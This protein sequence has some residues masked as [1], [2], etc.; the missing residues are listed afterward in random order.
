MIDPY[1]EAVLIRPKDDDSKDAYVDR[2]A[3]IVSHD[4]QG[5]FEY[6]VFSNSPRGKEYR[7]SLDRIITLGNPQTMDLTEATAIEVEGQWLHD[8]THALRFSS[9][10]GAWIR[11]FFE[12]SNRQSHE[13]YPESSVR[14]L[15]DEAH[16]KAGE[17][18]TH[19]KRI[20]AALPH[21]SEGKVHPT[22]YA[23]KSLTTIHPESALAQF[24]AEAPIKKFDDGVEPIFPFY[25]NISQREAAMQ[26]LRNSISII[27]GPPGTGKTQTILNIIA[28]LIREPGASVGV[29]SFNNAAVN[30]VLSKLEGEG[31]G[32]VVANLGNNSRKEEFFN[33][34][35]ERNAAVEIACATL[36]DDEFNSEELERVNA[37]LDQLQHDER[38]LAQTRDEA[39]AFL[40]E[41]EHFQR[42]LD[43]HDVQDLDGVPILTKASDRILDFIVEARHH[44]DRN[45]A[46]RWIRRL[47]WRV[48]YGSLRD[49]DYDDSGT[50]LRLQ[51]AYYSRKISELQSQ[52]DQLEER[53]EHADLKGLLAKQ[54]ELSVHAFEHGLHRR[55]STINRTN[56]D[57]KT[58]RKNFKAFL[59]DYPV[60]LSTCHSLRNSMGQGALL[61]YIIID[62]ASQLDLLTG[63]LA[64][65]SCKRL[66]VVGDLEQLPHIADEKAAAVAGP[67]PSPAH[68]YTRHSVLSSLLE[69]YGDNIPRT[70]LREHYRCHP[71]IIGFCNEEFYGEQLI[72]CRESTPS[73]T[74]LRLVRTPPGNHM[75]QH[76]SGGR[77][78]RREAEVVVDEII[79]EL[80]KTIPRDDIGV[81]S[82]YRKQVETMA[83]LLTVDHSDSVE[84]DTV[85]RY[86]GREKKVIVMSTVL[87]ETWRGRTGT[88]FVDDPKL[89]NVAVSRAIEQF[90]LVTDHDMLPTSHHL[91]D[92]MRYIAYHNPGEGL[93][94]SQIISVFDLLYKNYSHRLRSLASRLGDEMKYLSEE[95]I[96]T[97]L[98]D[99]LAEEKYRGLNVQPQILLRNL[100]PSLDGLTE[101]QRSFVRHNASLDF[102]IY[103]SMSRIPVLAIEVN[104]FAFHEN[105]PEQL[106]RDKIKEATLEN[107]GLHL[108]PLATTESRE[109]ERIRAA[110]DRAMQ[111]I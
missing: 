95:I 107:H 30:N 73:P 79:K 43:G 89:V 69:V 60:L 12:N 85:H 15:K 108:L 90:I 13:L 94:E 101:R 78:N 88:V 2:T 50:I 9:P 93:I 32:Y 105:N 66:I 64:L 27:D 3:E 16:R 54:K 28:S 36:R 102:V 91:R 110:L 86:Q 4:R 24:L 8:A 14:F 82:P 63:A 97:L 61:D 103:H 44:D 87:D 71:E 48:L 6:V 72:P 104:G 49:V 59:D 75:R 17:I 18:L 83:D 11:F 45:W 46:S 80:C 38:L 111:V 62:E 25:S 22:Q 77:S 76:R 96:W 65:A 81:A 19:W 21:M 57:Q 74:P 109:E 5:N 100:L 55:Y 34:Q 41:R 84:A 53:L 40:L 68:D 31:Y 67:A 92:L 39:R 42:Y 58:Y 99:I 98:K 7:Y 29:V 26:A 35:D 51:E 1:L 47:R 70:M 10:S 33:R 20:V 52:I 37:E 106:A 23:Y 56:Y